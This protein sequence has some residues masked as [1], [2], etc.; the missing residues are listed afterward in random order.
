MGAPNVKLTQQWETASLK[1]GP[2]TV[3][4]G[5]FAAVIPRSEL[6]VSPNGG[7]TFNLVGF[8]GP[9]GDSIAGLNNSNATILLEAGETVTSADLFFVYEYET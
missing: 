7:T 3:P 8:A 2:Y 6:I 9:A 5:R 4:A 1:G